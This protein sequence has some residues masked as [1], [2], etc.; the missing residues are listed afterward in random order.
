MANPEDIMEKPE[1]VI[2]YN[3]ARRDARVIKRGTQFGVQYEVSRLDN[4]WCNY[5]RPGEHRP[6]AFDLMTDAKKQ[7]KRMAG[8]V[9]EQCKR[10]R[11]T[12][13]IS[14][15]RCTRKATLDG[16]CTIHHPDYLSPADKA[17]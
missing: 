4:L 1:I 11:S 3:G 5:V 13:I 6:H 17:N 8:V 7:A 15:K 10:T 16:F 9:E 14:M 2:R 12:G